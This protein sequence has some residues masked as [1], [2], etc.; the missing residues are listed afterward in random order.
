[1]AYCAGCKHC[2][3]ETSESLAKNVHA[4]K[5]QL[6]Q[7]NTALHVL[8]F[9]VSGMLKHLEDK[10]ACRFSPVIFFTVFQLTKQPPATIFPRVATSPQT[11]VL[12]Q[13]YCGRKAEVMDHSVSSHRNALYF[14]ADAQT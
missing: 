7:L 5:E 2:I 4:V 10:T 12:A 14:S 6:F 3:T 8:L 11:P 9:P 1:M 13:C